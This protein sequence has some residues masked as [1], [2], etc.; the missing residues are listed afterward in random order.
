[1][2]NPFD[3]LQ[4]LWHYHRARRLSFTDRPALLAHQASE[5]NKHLSWVAQH[6]PYYSGL[7]GKPLNR[8]PVIDKQVWMGEFDRL[9]TAGLKLESVLSAALAAERSRNFADKHQGHTVGLSS[10]TSGSRGVFVV[11]DAERVQ[12][13]G[14]ALARLLPGR[15][16]NGERIAFFL[17]ANSNLYTSVQSPWLTF[18][19]F[20]LLQPMEGHLAHLQAYA[21]TAIVAPAQVL[22]YLAQAQLSG[23]LSIK[24]PRVV[25]VAEVLEPTDAMLLS[26][27]FGTPEQVYQATEGFLGY[28]C[29]HGTMHLNEEYY[30]VEREW[31]D[32]SKTKF[33]PVVT[34]LRR[35]VQPLIRYR[36][37]DVLTAQHSPCTCGNPALTI[38]HIDGRCD[39]MLSFTGARGPV[40]IFADTVSRLL[41]QRLPVEVD[42]RLLQLSPNYLKLQAPLP[43]PVGDKLLSELLLEFAKLG[44][45]TDELVTHFER[46]DV[47]FDPSKKRRRI[48]RVSA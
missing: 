35:K 14:L 9:N 5:L 27:A 48:Q 32:T 37:T 26:K 45:H 8:W 29:S 41:A 24:P 28:T 47:K 23:R 31:L 15:L 33:L 16:L 43:Q 30:V 44:A 2:R 4:V 42:Y 1:M 40:T 25:S 6:S 18:K 3:P 46:T 11:N 36:L 17:R 39:D 10:G 7:Q 12:W 13:A 21:P 34:D 20:D 38:A 22:A 19:F